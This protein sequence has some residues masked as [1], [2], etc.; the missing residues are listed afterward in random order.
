MGNVLS[1]RGRIRRLLQASGPQLP[2]IP[3][4]VALAA[5]RPFLGFGLWYGRGGE[6]KLRVAPKALHKM[7]VRVRQ[8]TRRTRGR[9]LADVVQSLAAYLNGWR[10]YFRVAATNKRFRELDE[11]IRHRLRAYQL[12]QWKRGTTVFRELHARGMSAN[13]AA[14]VAANARRW[15]RNS[16]MAIHIALPNKLF[17]GLGLP[18]LAP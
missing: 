18:R 8:L 13:A 2:V 16:A 7:K 9:S 4:A 5:S 6:V 1:S 15:W 17:D 11:W 10:G 12:K 14:Q 3:R